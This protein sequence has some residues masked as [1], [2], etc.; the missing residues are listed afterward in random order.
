MTTK[1]RG[2]GRG[3]SDLGLSELLGDMNKPVSTEADEQSSEPVKEP[4]AES[5]AQAK[6]SPAPPTLKPVAAQP[7]PQDKNNT[8]QSLPVE[9]IHPGRYQPR[10]EIQ[11]EDLEE[12]AASIKAQGIIQPIVVRKVSNGYEL[13]AGERRWRAAQL[14][15]LNVV[16]AIVREINDE[17]ALAIGIIENIQRRDLNAIEEAN[18]LQR[19]INEFSLTHQEVA[20]A[21]G[22]SRTMV[23]NLL[24]LLKLNPQ[25]RSLVEK[26]LLE[27]GHARALL[28]LDDFQQS[29]VAN[30]IVARKLSVRETEALIRR[31]QQPAAEKNKK[32]MPIDPNVRSLQ[33][34][35]SDKLG[36]HVAIQHN[37]KGKGK[38]VIHF[39]DLDELDGILGH[40]E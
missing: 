36:A 24:R 15:G 27:M 9:R 6:D 16:P 2:L 22:K 23:T 14:A 34:D 20:D 10:G 31:M 12:L 3:L 29:D 28:A 32:Q 25:V 1:K 26:N 33:N 40:I 30:Q 18:A 5:P 8:F 39:N 35:L 4:T 7:T 19:L 13:I 17:A 37:A 38:L 11:T 21:V